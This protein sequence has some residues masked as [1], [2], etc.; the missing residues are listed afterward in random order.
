M[1]YGETVVTVPYVRERWTPLFDL[2][3]STCW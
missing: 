1:T 2:R 3:P